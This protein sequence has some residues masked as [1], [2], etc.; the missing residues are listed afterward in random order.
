MQI[1]NKNLFIL[2]SII[3]SISLFMIDYS[4]LSLFIYLNSLSLNYILYKD[5]KFE[6][7]NKYSNINFLFLPNYYPS[8]R[9]FNKYLIIINSSVIYIGSILLCC[10]YWLNNYKGIKNESYKYIF[11]LMIFSFITTFIVFANIILLTY[12]MWVF[13]YSLLYNYKN[14]KALFA[15]DH[16]ENYYYCWVCDKILSKNKTLKKLNCPCQEYFHPDCINNYLSLYNN[17]CRNGH[18]IAKYE[19]T[20]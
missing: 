1:I 16:V 13:L 10:D 3:N 4:Y 7:K 14:K 17:Y 2:V 11:T 19:H 18:K 12:S 5:I 15:I 8:N 6:I 20:A 9:T